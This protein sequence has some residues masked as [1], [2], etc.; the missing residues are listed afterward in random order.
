MIFVI[1]TFQKIGI[2]YFQKQF[3]NKNILKNATVMVQLWMDQ[4]YF[5]QLTFFSFKVAH[6]F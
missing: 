5:T 3:G 6:F 4:R 1:V 2:W